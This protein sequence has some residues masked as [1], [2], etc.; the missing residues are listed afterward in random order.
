MCK[1]NPAD[2][3]F[4]STRS[5]FS[6][7][8]DCGADDEVREAT[9]HI[10]A[11]CI[12]RGPPPPQAP[13]PLPPRQFTRAQ[14]AAV[15]SGLGWTPPPTLSSPRRFRSR[16]GWIGRGGRAPLPLC[17]HKGVA[18]TQLSEPFSGAAGSTATRL[19]FDVIEVL[20]L[21]QKAYIGSNVEMLREQ[22]ISISGCK[23]AFGASPA[24]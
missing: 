3:P 22:W 19:P 9:S 5:A 23:I 1:Q 20:D 24:C 8:C 21:S 2:F 6:S 14:L 10:N 11:L 18:L 16:R 13:P 17:G 15:S 7:C 12:V 4:I